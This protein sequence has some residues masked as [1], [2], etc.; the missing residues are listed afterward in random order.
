MDKRVMEATY[1]CHIPEGSLAAVD[2]MLDVMAVTPL[3][4]SPAVRESASFVPD[5]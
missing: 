1:E 2:P 4:G 5:P 3:W